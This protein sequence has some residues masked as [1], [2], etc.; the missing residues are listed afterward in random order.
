MK[1]YTP[2]R[3]NLFAQLVLSVGVSQKKFSELIGKSTSYVGD[4]FTGRRE[5]PYSK[6]LLLAEK[7]GVDI[8]VVMNKK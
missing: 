8:E 3:G 5:M 1:T 4:Y 2:N 6:I 7:V